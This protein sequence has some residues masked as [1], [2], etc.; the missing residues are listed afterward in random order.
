MS[1]S[2][3]LRILKPWVSI[4]MLAVQISCT[5]G[6]DYDVRNSEIFT[7]AKSSTKIEFTTTQPDFT[8]MTP[9]STLVTTINTGLALSTRADSAIANTTIEG[10]VTMPSTYGI[11]LGSGGTPAGC[12]ATDVYARSFVLQDSSGG[13]LVAYGLEPPTQDTAQSTSMKYILNARNSNRAI[14]GDRIRLTATRAV[15]YGNTTGEIPI[16]TDFNSIQI[17]SSRNNIPYAA[18]TT[19]LSRAADLYRVRQVEGYVITK[20]TYGECGNGQDREFQYNFQR[21]YI[22]RLCIGATSI[23]DA[24][25]C[26]GT[27]IP[28]KFQ[29]SLYL[30]AGTLSGFDTGDMYSYNINENAKVRL[31]GVV[32]PPQYDAA[33]VNL[34][35]NG[36]GNL[37]IMLGQ[38]LQVETIP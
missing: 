8:G 11:G 34:G 19:Q 15:R 33:D 10:I 22:G 3:K 12:A 2:V 30:G 36:E 13:I 23:A 6:S 37:S 16:V 18:Q 28:I 27:K 20:A 38:R 26:T 32:F 31:R 9:I 35:S 25:D 4:L 21:G 5:S 14:F 7:E 17:I 1:E 24:G 29:M